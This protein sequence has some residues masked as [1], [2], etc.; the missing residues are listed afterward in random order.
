MTAGFGH[1]DF[2]S[3]PACLKCRVMALVDY[4]KARVSAQPLHGD[5]CVSSVIL[6][7]SL[8]CLCDLAKSTLSVGTLISESP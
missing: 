1:N 7:H 2:V 3:S 5:K 8:I 4:T 6:D